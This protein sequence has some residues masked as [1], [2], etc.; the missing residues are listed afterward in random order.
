[1][2]TTGRINVDGIVRAGGSRVSSGTV[3]TP[4][5][6]LLTDPD[7]GRAVG[8]IAH[9]PTETLNVGDATATAGTVPYPSE[10]LDIKN[11]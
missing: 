1:M 6:T 11:V 7:S 9:A 3:P 4:T 10:S 5:Q 2:P 8:E